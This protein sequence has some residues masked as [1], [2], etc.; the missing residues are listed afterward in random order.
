MNRWLCW[1]GFIETKGLS[2]S[3]EQGSREDRGANAGEKS[4]EL[5]TGAKKVYSFGGTRLCRLPPQ[6]EA[7]Q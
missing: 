4:K 5:P 2:G 3:R 1:G 6:G 7:R